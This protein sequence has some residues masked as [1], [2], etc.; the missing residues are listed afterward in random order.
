MAK[1]GEVRQG[2]PEMARCL[3]EDFDGS[4]VAHRKTKGRWAKTGQGRRCLRNSELGEA[5]PRGG[6]VIGAIQQGIGSKIY[7]RATCRKQGLN[8]IPRSRSR[9]KRLKAEK[10]PVT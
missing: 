7:T 10:S 6:G 2:A 1:E 5:S 8:R 3:E 9:M 4:S